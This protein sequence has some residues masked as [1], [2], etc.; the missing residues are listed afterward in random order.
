MSLTYSDLLSKPRDFL[1]LAGDA[2]DSLDV[3]SGAARLFTV[4]ITGPTVA[5]EVEIFDSLFEAWRERLQ[6]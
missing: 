2:A 1:I 6:S 5:A 3:C 4:T